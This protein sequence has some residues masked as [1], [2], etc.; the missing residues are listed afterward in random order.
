MPTLKREGFEH[1]G[2]AFDRDMAAARAA[3]DE[4]DLNRAVDL[5]VSPEHVYYYAKEPA[6]FE[7]L[8]DLYRRIG[9]T[10]DESIYPAT[11]Q[12]TPW[13]AKLMAELYALWP[14]VSLDCAIL[15]HEFPEEEVT[16]LERQVSARELD[17]ETDAR[18]RQII[19]EQL[20]SGA[21]S[22]SRA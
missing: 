5:A 6:R 21:E 17:S 18:V 4:G 20:V 10:A 2:A 22:C 15:R 3:L 12:A 1:E 13:Q 16:A 19:N 14:K 9:T 7:L 8:R 11:Y